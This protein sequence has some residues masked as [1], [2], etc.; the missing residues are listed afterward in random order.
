MSFLGLTTDIVLTA[1]PSALTKPP[2]VAQ[3]EEVAAAALV[4]VEATTLEAEVVIVEEVDT[5]C[6]R[7]AQCLIAANRPRRWRRLRWWT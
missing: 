2:S 6:V 1:V 5:A 4:V 7:T 3:V